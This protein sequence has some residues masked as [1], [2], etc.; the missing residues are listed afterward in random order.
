LQPPSAGDLRSAG[1]GDPHDESYVPRVLVQVYRING[2][3]PALQS[4]AI[5]DHGRRLPT[6]HQSREP[7]ITV[8]D[9]AT[10][11]NAL[12]LRTLSYDV[13]ASGNAVPLRTLSGAVTGLQRPS[14]T[15]TPRCGRNAQRR[16]R[17]WHGNNTVTVY[18]RRGARWVGMMWTK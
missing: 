16:D 10:S 15:T 12:P 1:G 6:A 8:Y 11:G 3:E 2:E 4:G 14:V 18:T 17:G 7:K 5:C 9:V 13:A